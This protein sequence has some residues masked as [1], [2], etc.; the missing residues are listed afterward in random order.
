MGHPDQ[1]RPRFCPPCLSALILI[2]C[3]CRERSVWMASLTARCCSRGCR[4]SSCQ[5]DLF[6]A[7]FTVQEVLWCAAALPNRLIIKLEPSGTY[8]GRDRE[9]IDALKTDLK[10]GSKYISFTAILLTP[11]RLLYFNILPSND[12]G[13]KKDDFTLRVG[14]PWF[15]QF[16]ILFL[17]CS[18]E[19]V[20]RWDVLLINAC[21]ATLVGC[22]VGYGPWKNMG[23]SQTGVAKYNSILFFFVIHQGVIALW[24]Y[25]LLFY[26]VWSTVYST[27]RT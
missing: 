20:R 11:R 26:S 15:Y 10:K 22:F 21:V 16:S 12:F 23:T 24:L 25:C 1:E 27:V 6:H 17:R 13:V 9:E 19:W 5:D 3:L 7:H 14:I 8:Y 18:Q 2:A 4:A